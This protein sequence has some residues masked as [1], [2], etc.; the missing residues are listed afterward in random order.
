[1]HPADNICVS[2]GILQ[3]CAQ[4]KFMVN[5]CEFMA[6]YGKLWQIM[7]NYDKFMA[8]YGNKG[9]YGTLLAIFSQITPTHKL[10]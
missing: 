7:A 2:W 3:G 8:K 10:P 6:N 5:Y 9:S 4:F 1:M